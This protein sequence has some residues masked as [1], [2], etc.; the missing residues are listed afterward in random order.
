[1]ELQP[2]FVECED[3]PAA[4]A[5]EGSAIL[6]ETLRLL[7]AVPGLAARK[8]VTI[9]LGNYFTVVELDDGSV[10]AC[11]SY[12]RLPVPVLLSLR[13]TL[14]SRLADDPLLLGLLFGQERPHRRECLGD[15]EYLVIRCLQATVV[16]ALSAKCIMRGGDGIFQVSDTPPFDLFAG[17]ST[18][19]VIGF[20]GYMSDLI[21]TANIN[22][23]HVVD[24]YYHDRKR[25]IDEVVD[26][27]RNQHPR[28]A[29]SVSDGDDTAARLRH[30]DLVAITGSALCNGTM[31]ELLLGAATCKRIIVQGQSACMHPHALFARGVQVVVTSL[32]PATLVQLA[33]AD[34]NGSLLYSVLESE[35]VRIY[36]APRN[37]PDTRRQE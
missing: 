32:K 20:G 9:C 13:Q 14:T 10:G 23:L 8:I 36:L 6:S 12:Y 5:Q 2:T 31:E 1:M 18:A 4:R 34:P 37:L 16:N 3:Q 21:E 28:K 7:R 22:E 25:E 24:L 19:L 33:E 26:V 29:M 17:C 27:F 35:M 30:T 11:T 15:Q